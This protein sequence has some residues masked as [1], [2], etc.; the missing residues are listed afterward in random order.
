MNKLFKLLFKKYVHQA[1]GLGSVIHS[2]VGY[3]GSIIRGRMRTGKQIHH[4]VG[5]DGL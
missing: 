3:T 5:Y 1:N 4:G 2:G